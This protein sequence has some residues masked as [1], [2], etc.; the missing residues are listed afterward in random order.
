MQFV[1]IYKIFFQKISTNMYKYFILNE[2]LHT[3]IVEES[4]RYHFVFRQYFLNKK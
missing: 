3:T 4:H 2:K 1:E